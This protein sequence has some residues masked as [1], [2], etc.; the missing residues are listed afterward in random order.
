MIHTRKLGPEDISK[1]G[2]ECPGS[3]TFNPPAGLT[4]QLAFEPLRPEFPTDAAFLKTI[5]G[6]ILKPHGRKYV[7]LVLFRF[8]ALFN[9]PSLRSLLS[10]AVSDNN[11]DAVGNKW[12]LTSA[13]QQWEDA[14]NRDDDPNRP[15]YGLGMTLAGLTRC[16]YDLKKDL[17]YQLP[18]KTPQSPPVKTG[19]G[20]A[21]ND[22]QIA[23]ALGD[24]T[25][26][27][28]P[29]LPDWER[30]YREGIDGAFI[31]A[32]ND[33]VILSAMEV[34]V[35]D[36][37]AGHRAIKIAVE[38]GFTWTDVDDKPREPFG[39]R[40]GISDPIFFYNDCYRADPDCPH[41]KAYVPKWINIPLSQAMITDGDHTGGSFL[42]LRK[43]EQ[44]VAAFRQ[45]EAAIGRALQGKQPKEG[46]II[47]KEPGALLIGRERD[48]TPLSVPP[49]PNGLNVDSL[50]PN[51][52]DF[53]AEASRCPFHAHIRKSAPRVTRPTG[54]PAV[55]L[56]G[57][58]PDTF[59]AISALFVRRSAVYDTYAQLPPSK[60]ITDDPSK[61]RSVQSGSY[62]RRGRGAITKGVGL[63]FMGYMGNIGSQ[64]QELQMDW[65]GN[66]NFPFVDS[67]V[68]DPV[69]RHDM[70]VTGGKSEPPRWTWKQQ[71]PDVS[72]RLPKAITPRG[73]A[74]FYVPSITWL[75]NQ[76][77]SAPVWWLR[78]VRFM[79]RPHFT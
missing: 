45:A 54:N 26:D 75:A 37:L 36:F 43:L 39:F 40:D 35:T 28:T 38:N 20:D 72:V 32:C 47:P 34:Q 59:D 79:H 60:V 12:K 13:Y 5:Q 55:P 21:M 46:T 16:E 71:F 44:N 1:N 25:A 70:T 57:T 22:R 67:G 8:D 41:S 68:I 65:F 48:G 78:V 31:L 17:P 77:P 52:F 73:G 51:R 66:A 3:L 49:A 63:L 76:K 27:T 24:R 53:E 33:P 29:E 30:A 58:H 19:F 6:N 11:A 7:K 61:N 2:V 9:D 18:P 10:D 14:R 50:G 15:F 62:E 69:V 42:V 23:G 74:Y 64:F 4:C 56:P